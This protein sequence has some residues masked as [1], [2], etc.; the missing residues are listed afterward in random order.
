MYN[1]K[2]TT[3]QQQTK[4]RNGVSHSY[5]SH[6]L[7]VFYRVDT[8]QQVVFDARHV[9]VRHIPGGARL[10]IHVVHHRAKVLRKVTARAL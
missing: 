10:A 4:T 5:L 2:T 9:L 3:K 7:K 6:F 1:N 8:E